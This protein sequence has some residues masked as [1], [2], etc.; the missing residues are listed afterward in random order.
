MLI[1]CSRQECVTLKSCFNGLKTEQMS[2][3]SKWFLLFFFLRSPSLLILNAQKE[4]DRTGL[5]VSGG[6][7]VCFPSVISF[8][9]QWSA[10]CSMCCLW[11]WAV[12]KLMYFTFTGQPE[13][14]LTLFFLWKSGFSNKGL[15]TLVQYHYAAVLPLHFITSH[16]TLCTFIIHFIWSLVVSYGQNRWLQWEFPFDMS[17]QSS[18]PF[19][20][21]EK[22]HHILDTPHLMDCF[23]CWFCCCA[24]HCEHSEPSLPHLAIFHVVDSVSCFLENNGVLSWH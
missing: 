19:F 3:T 13:L 6:G 10:D 24:C 17:E 1:S 8:V 23:L 22:N 14:S 9:P 5:R 11:T 4:W 12:S 7:E 16:Q 2:F 18:P 20:R 15:V 21:W